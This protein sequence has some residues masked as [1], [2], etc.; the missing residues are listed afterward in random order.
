MMTTIDYLK[1]VLIC[2]IDD[3]DSV[4]LPHSELGGTHVPSPWGTTDQPGF[5][6]TPGEGLALYFDVIV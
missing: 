5:Q 4:N 2:H 6:M 3:L 1:L